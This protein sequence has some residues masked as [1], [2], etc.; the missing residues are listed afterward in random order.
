[1]KNPW[2]KKQRE[3]CDNV[4]VGLPA[5]SLKLP[6]PDVPPCKLSPSA[7]PQTTGDGDRPPPP[8][9]HSRGAKSRA[10]ILSP[11]AFDVAQEV[12]RMR[13]GLMYARDCAPRDSDVATAAYVMSAIANLT[14]E[15]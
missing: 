11:T 15:K 12:V 1:M 9:G 6:M 3:R 8:R 13:K 7:Q 10:A 2:G 4:G 14:K 5:A